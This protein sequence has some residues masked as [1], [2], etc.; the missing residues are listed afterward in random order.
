MTG[1]DPGLIGPLAALP[2]AA[3]FVVIAVGL[4][5]SIAAPRAAA[6]EFGAALGLGLD[7]LLAAGL[8]RLAARPDVRALGLVALV[9]AVRKVST[10]GVKAARR[11]VGG[12][13][14]M[15]LRA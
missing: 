3:A 10:A 9:I 14:G 6:A 4:L 2:F 8:I 7:F 15:R 13:A 5:R 1:L 11:A 12:V